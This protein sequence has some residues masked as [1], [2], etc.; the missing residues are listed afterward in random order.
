DVEALDRL[1]LGS[2]RLALGLATLGGAWGTVD[3]A[4]S[5]ATVWHALE[6]GVRVFDVAP[7]YGAAESLLGSVLKEWC[8]PMPIISTK[9]GRIPSGSAHVG[10]YD[11][12]PDGIRRS[13]ESSLKA[14][15]RPRVD[16]VFLHEPHIVPP[17]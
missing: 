4:E 5:R 11:Y 10:H 13:L 9:V 3:E 1:G 12:T 7:A 2:S 8:G 14:L 15:G 17:E 6:Q 16:L